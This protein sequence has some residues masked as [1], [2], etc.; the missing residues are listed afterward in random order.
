ME[1]LAYMA[2]QIVKTTD[3]I[4]IVRALASACSCLLQDSGNFTGSPM[5]AE[6]I[7]GLASA[8]DDGVD[9]ATV[10]KTN[11]ADA[12]D[13]TVGELLAIM[14]ADG[15][16]LGALFGVYFLA[17]NKKITPQNRSA[18]NEKRVSAATASIIGTAKIFVND[19]PYLADDVLANCYAAFI[20]CAPLRANLTHKVVNLLHKQ[21]MGPALAFLN[22]FLLLQD[23][24]MS[25][26]RLIKEAT[27]KHPW[28]RTEFPN[29]RPEFSAANTAQQ[30]LKRAPGQERS[31]LKAIHGSAFVPVNYSEIDNL[32][33][34]CKE[35]MKRTTPSYQNYGG[36]KI[37]PAQ[38]AQISNHPDVAPATVEAV[39]AE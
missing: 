1:V 36:G 32:T 39:T 23:Q 13:V 31:F 15:D 33:G 5:K 29:L 25:A 18:F 21:Y 34:V 9:P 19:S 4:V 27:I 10:L 11:F 6:A 14:E 28:I 2:L 37:T 3:K 30:I 20:S 35:I 22:M 8:A 24:G 26:L 12:E 7:T 17:G 16:E 38:L